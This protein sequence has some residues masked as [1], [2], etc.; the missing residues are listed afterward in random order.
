MYIY[1]YVC[2]DARESVCIYLFVRE[3]EGVYGCMYMYVCFC[4]Y[5]YLL[6]VY[7]SLT[8]ALTELPALLCASIAAP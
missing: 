3:I 8:S 1:M 7:L 2:E 6:S 5:A 4:K